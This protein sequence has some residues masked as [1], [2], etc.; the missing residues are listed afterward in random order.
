MDKHNYYHSLGVRNEMMIQD[1]NPV[2][3]VACSFP[4][5][6]LKGQAEWQIFQL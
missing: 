2:K 5:H 4:E 6:V 1:N 3:Y